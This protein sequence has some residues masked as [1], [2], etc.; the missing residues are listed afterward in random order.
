M[1]DLSRESLLNL[2]HRG[3]DSLC[4]QKGADFYGDLM[5]EDGV[6]ILVNGYVM[7]LDEVVAVLN[8]AP[9][10]D[11]YELSD[12]RVIP[13]GDDAAALVYRATAQR[14]TDAPFEAIMTSVYRVVDGDVKLAL[15]QQTTATH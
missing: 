11:S 4:E 7:S 15:Y 14:G 3:W 5:T 2:E 13:L 6:Q 10:W 9:A 12:A 1:P 8:Q